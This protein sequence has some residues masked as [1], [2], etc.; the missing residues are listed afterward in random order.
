[1]ATNVGWAGGIAPSDA[2]FDTGGFRQRLACLRERRRPADVTDIRQARDVVMV[3]TSPRGGSSFFA[4]LIRRSPAFTHLSGE[5]TPFLDI[6][7]LTYPHSGTGSD[8]LDERHVER[9]APGLVEELALDAGWHDEAETFDVETAGTDL[10]FRLM[11]Q[12]PRLEFDVD[13]VVRGTDEVVAGLVRS[14]RCLPGRYPS[15]IDF[16]LEFL[17]LV[18]R[19]LGPIINPYYYDIDAALVRARLPWGPPPHGPVGDP[20]VEVAPFLPLRPWHHANSVELAER[21]LLIKS[22]SNAYRLHLFRQLFA[23]ARFRVVHLVRNP[24]ASITGLM[25]GWRHHGFFNWRVVKPLSICGYSDVFPEW[26][27]SWWNFD[28]PPGWEAW[29][30]QPLARVCAFQWRAGHAAILDFLATS[31]VESFRIRYE[32]I[33]PA[34][35]PRRQVLSALAEWLGVPAEPLGRLA[36]LDVGPV[37]ATSPPGRSRWRLRYDELRPVVGQA[38]VLEMAERLGYGRDPDSWP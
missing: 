14:G 31:G 34:G 33:L 32:D 26:G 10:T 21:P 9:A 20:I 2:P 3:V 16:Q 12:W 36:D 22:S 4:E 35:E 5:I 25:D 15:P 28:M 19:R 13:D 38:F 29:A 30:D 18:H 8:L 1:M 37:V 11:V 23:N 7:G 17:A 27:R 24:A 6:G